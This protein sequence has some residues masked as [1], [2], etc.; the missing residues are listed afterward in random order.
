MVEYWKL[1]E[2]RIAHLVGGRRTP[3]SGAGT[4]KGD[5]WVNRDWM[6][7]CKATR[8][9]AFTLSIQMLDKLARQSFEAGMSAALIIAFFRGYSQMDVAVLCLERRGS[10]QPRW[11]T[12]KVTYEDLANIPVIV[13]KYAQWK[14]ISLQELENMVG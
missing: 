14:T 4:R 1:L 6:L 9:S 12:R 13:S 5:I 3:A 2:Q 7:E 8:A 10:F 11:K